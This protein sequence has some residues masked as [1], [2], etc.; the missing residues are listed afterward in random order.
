MK[1]VYDFQTGD[2]GTEWTVDPFHQKPF[3]SVVD[4]GELLRHIAQGRHIAAPVFS[5]PLQQGLG[6]DI[7]AADGELVGPALEGVFHIAVYHHVLR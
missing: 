6:T 7:I 2:D 3:L 5:Q 4:E 1:L